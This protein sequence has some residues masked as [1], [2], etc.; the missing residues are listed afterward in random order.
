MPG[1]R[2]TRIEG[3]KDEIE[4][5][6]WSSA[7]VGLPRLPDVLEPSRVDLGARDVL[8]V[9]T[10][11]FGDPLGSGDGDVGRLFADVL[12][13]GAPSLLEFAHVLD[14]SRETFDDDRTLV[15]VWLA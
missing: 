11:G 6:L 1:G 10:D 14:F 9:G 3:G 8:L 5:G 15:A 2:F 4:G 12:G 7:V 13:G